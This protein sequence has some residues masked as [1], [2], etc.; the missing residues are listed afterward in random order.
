MKP[1]N[2]L[3]G[4]IPED[5]SIMGK[6]IW[7]ISELY[8]PEET[9]TGFFL[10]K[11][12]EGLTEQF[13]VSVLC[14]QPTYGARGERAAISEIHK[15]VH[16]HRSWGTTF[17][18][19]VLPLRLVNIVTITFSILLNAIWRVRSGDC[20]LV[21]TNPPA[22]PFAV[23]LACF[24]HRVPCVLIIHDV[25]PEILIAAG[26]TRQGSI[27]NRVIGCLTQMMYR[28]MSRII[29]LGRDM[30]QLVVRKL[31]D[32][33]QC[34]VTIPNWADLDV[35]SPSYRKENKLL[36]QLGCT[37][38]FVVQYAGNMGRTH[39][40]EDLVCCAK[41]LR[42]DAMIH[43]LI[44]GTGAKR[45]WIQEIVNEQKINNI[46]ILDYQPRA[47]LSNTLNACDVAIIVF[48]KGMAGVSVPSRM[49]NI[50]ATGK[51]IIAV[52]DAES[53]LALVVREEDIGWVIYPGD[54]GGLRMAILEAKA[55]PDVLVQMGQRARRAAEA[56]YSFER[57]KKAYTEMVASIYEEAV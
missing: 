49:Y 40:L 41:E 17:N 8:Y 56:K 39:G 27:L 53:E 44:I 22:L 30:V 32:G 36:A 9:S 1:V 5:R 43:F 46:T 47:D 18:K 52:A 28:Q 33:D 4:D 3:A 24:L 51:P 57:V 55:N 34:I 7:V 20:V 35:V 12:A 38:K 54:I 13:Q 50:M 48:V 29:V 42:N 21:V 45:M 31:P 14:S 11:I 10:T 6:R 2:Y 26:I 25:Y 16:I 19:D 23:S 15:G 37:D